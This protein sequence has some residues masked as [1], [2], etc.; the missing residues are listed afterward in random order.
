MPV[1]QELRRVLS[2][3]QKDLLS[4]LDLSAPF[5]PYETEWHLKM[6]E[7]RLTP[8]S[9]TPFNQLNLLSH[10]RVQEVQL[11]IRVATASSQLP[12]PL[13]SYPKCV[14][15]ASIKSPTAFITAFQFR[16]KRISA[17]ER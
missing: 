1:G 11:F 7:D 8:I 14:H 12:H 3:F 2:L 6:A 16:E 15:L 5:G 10:R 17:H 13:A 4:L 9:M